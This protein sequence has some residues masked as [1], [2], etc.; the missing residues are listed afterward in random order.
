MKTTHS[1][2]RRS[3]AGLLLL[4]APTVV[5]AGVLTSSASAA[6]PT[7]INL[8]TAA[9]TSVLAGAG[10]TN[11]GP[12]V[13]S[14]DLDTSPNPAITG[15]PPGIVNGAQHAAD[16]VAGAAQS[17]L[18]TAYNQAASAPSTSDVTGVD[19]SGKTLTQGVFTASTGMALNGPLALT[20]NGGPDAVFIFQAGSTLITGSN[21]S[22]VLTGGAQ[23]CNVFWQVGS[24]ATLGTNTA[25]VGTILAETAIT[26]NTGATVAG[27]A[28]ARTASVTLDNNT[29]T[30][31]A[32]APTS[33]TTTPTTS[34]TVATT[35]KS[36]TTP[37]TVR[38]P[39]AGTPGGPGSAGPGGAAVPTAVTPPRAPPGGGGSTLFS[40]PI[41]GSPGGQTPTTP[42]VPAIVGPPRTGGAP[43][44]LRAS[45]GLPGIGWL[46]LGLGVATGLGLLTWSRRRTLRTIAVR[47]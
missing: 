30:N 22:V 40:P 32:C 4:L 23:A 14:N 39:V 7:T 38:T 34:T 17:D 28:L 8:G 5:F 35:P 36:P 9:A 16:A 18:T 41:P 46:V 11:T 47:P 37:T 24:S 25:F 31:A 21:S 29:F 42:G 6:T 45:A 44:A 33:T 15:F 13:L 3:T 19:L 10:V 12:S 26:L 1:P 2:V 20:L 27:R 43:Q